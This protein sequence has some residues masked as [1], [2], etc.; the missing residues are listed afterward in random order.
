ML[1]TVGCIMRPTIVQ[2]QNMALPVVTPCSLLIIVL[3]VVTPCSL[4]IIVL[5]VVTPCSLAG[6]D[7]V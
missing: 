7:A 4:M 5:S 2:L 6:C 3:S 1:L